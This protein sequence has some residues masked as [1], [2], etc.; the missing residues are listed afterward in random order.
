MAQSFNNYAFISTIRKYVNSSILL[1][2][3]TLLALV[4]ANM[5]ATRELYKH[6]WTLPVQL[7][8]GGF[9]IFTHAGHPMTL[10]AFINDFLMA[11]FFLSVGLEIK[12]EV[13]CGELSSVKK[14]LLPV[15]GACGGMIVPVIVFFFLCGLTL[16]DPIAE[17]GMAIP[18]ATDIAF[19]LGVL[20]MFSKRVP[21]GLKVF[22]AALAVADDLGGILVIAI[23]YTDHLNTTYLLYA[24]L[25]VAILAVGNLRQVRAT[26][27]YMGIGLALWYFMQGSGIHSTIAGV[28]LAFCVPAN[29]SNGTKFYIERIRHNIGLFPVIEVTREERNK[30]AVLSDDQISLLKSIESASDHLISPLQNLE[31]QLK[32]PIN[33]III[34]LFAF[35]N[36]GVDFSNMGIESLVSGVGLSVFMGLLVGKFVGVF[37]FSWV[38]I[39][40]GLVQMPGNA[41][42]AAFA[43]VCMLCGIGFTVSTFMADISYSPVGHIDYLNDAKLGILC[44]TVASALM[45]SLMLNHSLP[46]K[47]DFPA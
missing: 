25:C 5:D 4:V 43:G 29:L 40:T 34:P 28:L 20:S 14:A 8:L 32:S 2:A 36:A 46:K 22:L 7:S 15:I 3:S 16:S 9:N 13:L 33:Y 26:I 23:K 19:S 47:G 17:R 38:S 24:L 31:D 39:R 45:G 21:I 30:P 27:F 37:T 11:I 10:G 42:W 35:A 12:R 18:M 41:S 1:V 44:G 6:L